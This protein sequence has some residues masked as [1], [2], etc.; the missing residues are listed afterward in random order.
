MKLVPSCICVPSL[1]LVL[2]T[3]TLAQSPSHTGRTAE[4]AAKM[5][6][7]FPEK[8]MIKLGFK[9]RG[10][11]TTPASL[12]RHGNTIRSRGPVPT[13]LPGAGTSATQSQASPSKTGAAET[14]LPPKPVAKEHIDQISTE[15]AAFKVDPVQQ[16]HFSEI[17]FELDSSAITSGSHAILQGI[18][19]A[20]KSMPNRRFLVEGHTC[21][22]GPLEHNTRL[23]CL[24]AETVCAWLIHY[25]ALP[26]QLSPAG[27]G[28]SDPVAPAMLAPDPTTKELARSKNRRAAFRLLVD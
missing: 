24:R 19:L 1:A 9:A 7:A 18:A 25:G 13:L 12:T 28:P 22:L 8:P 11:N 20:L 6:A 3:H 14:T 4:A 17:L 16:V 23:S 21:D 27:F 2:F 5:K 26:T 15:P 10:T